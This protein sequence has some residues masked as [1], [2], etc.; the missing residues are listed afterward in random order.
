[1]DGVVGRLKSVSPGSI[2]SDGLSK[3]I[4]IPSKPYS[5]T[6]RVT[7]ETKFGTRCGSASVKCWP[8]PPSEIITFRP[9]LFR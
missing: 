7:D 1:M 4:S 5:E 3:S 8:P 2:D 6:M 9:W